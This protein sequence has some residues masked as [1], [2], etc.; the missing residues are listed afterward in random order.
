MKI[1]RNV[2]VHYRAYDDKVYETVFYAKD[3]KDILDTIGPIKDLFVVHT[4][5]DDS[6]E[7]YDK[8]PCPPPSRP[9]EDPFKGWRHK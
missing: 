9:R 8:R 1:D 3:S 4:V 6:I 5:E 7:P 2:R